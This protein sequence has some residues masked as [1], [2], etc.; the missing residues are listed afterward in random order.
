[1][2]QARTPVRDALAAVSDRIAALALA[3]GP[4]ERGPWLFAHAWLADSRFESQG[5]DPARLDEACADLA[6]LPGDFPS[7]ELRALAAFIERIQGGDPEGA[8]A[9]LD[10]A[11]EVARSLLAQDSDSFSPAEAYE[12]IRRLMDLPVVESSA[13]DVFDGASDDGLGDDLGDLTDLG[14]RSAA[15]R[16]SALHDKAMGH[17]DVGTLPALVLATDYARQSLAAAAQDD[18]HRPLYLL[19]TAVIHLRRAETTG[20]HD[21]TEV[22]AA[23]Q[24][25]ELARTAAGSVAHP[26]WPRISTVLALAYRHSGRAM[27]S[28]LVAL[29]GLYGRAYDIQRRTDPDELRAAADEGA[30]DALTVARWCLTD[31]D[32]DGAAIAAEVNRGLILY[33]AAEDRDDA[34]WLLDPP[35]MQDMQSALSSHGMDALVYLIPGDDVEGSA[36]IVRPGETLDWIPLPQLSSERL[37]VLEQAAIEP[38]LDVLGETRE[39]TDLPAG[40]DRRPFRAVLIPL[41]EPSSLPWPAEQH[42][43]DGS[44]VFSC[45]A[46]ARMYCQDTTNADSPGDA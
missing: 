41:A 46:S 28:R 42:S 36:V 40:T 17:L 30:A 32:P 1:M 9:F 27:E 39:E 29:D 2:N 25:A 3:S 20:D 24:G 26:L 33:A 7:R 14:G 19:T 23:V 43:P 31:D 15:E 18:P 4:D 10:Q 12:A 8:V 13:G 22:A 44:L 34:A 5:R 6:A 11:A 45:A 35:T 21:G 37:A 38:L 16:A